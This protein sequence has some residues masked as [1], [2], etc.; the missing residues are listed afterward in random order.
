MNLPFKTRYQFGV[1]ERV[2]SVK[3]CK[4]NDDLIQLIALLSGDHL[5]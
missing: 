1:E 3:K 5:S 2:H 4:G